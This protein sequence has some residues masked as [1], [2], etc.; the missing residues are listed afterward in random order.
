MLHTA[1][2]NQTNSF[3]LRLS[4]LNTTVKGSLAAFSEHCNTLNKSHK[5]SAIKG[6]ATAARGAKGE[7][8]DDL[9]VCAR[10]GFV[11]DKNITVLASSCS[12]IRQRPV[13]FLHAPITV[14]CEYFC[15]H[16]AG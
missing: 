8:I 6:Y 5:R 7:E 1:L 14:I 13:M 16:V 2:V 9:L 12:V 15:V 10:V 11:N 3:N 4:E